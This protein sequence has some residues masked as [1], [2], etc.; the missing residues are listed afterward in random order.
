MVYQ[1]KN[2]AKGGWQKLSFL[3]QMANIGSE[4]IRALNWRA[5]NN[6]EYAQNAFERS[7]ELF[8]LTS[9]DPKNISRLGEVLRA[10]ECWVDFFAYDNEYN[11]TEKQWEKYFFAF[12]WAA[13]K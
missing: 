7:L 11:S 2:L 4:V 5:K 12:N 9:A 1:H 3:A 6:E 8:D 13:N 10:R